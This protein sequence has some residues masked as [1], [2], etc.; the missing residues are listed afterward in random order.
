MPTFLVIET[1]SETVENGPRTIMDADTPEAAAGIVIGTRTGVLQFQ[2]IDTANLTQVDA[3][4]DATVTVNSASAA[5][6]L[7]I[8]QHPDEDPV[9]NIDV[10]DQPIEP[11]IVKPGPPI[12]IDP[13]LQG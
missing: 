11:I 12:H 8:A 10:S 1:T 7:N 6:V 3:Y 9:I 4:S 13:P 2:V 5:V